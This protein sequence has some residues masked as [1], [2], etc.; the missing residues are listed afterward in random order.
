MNH[1][2]PAIN[3][4]RDYILSKNTYFRNGY[5]NTIVLDG[6]I[7]SDGEGIFPADNLG[8]YFYFRLASNIGFD[9]SNVL[10]I[11]DNH[12]SVGMRYDITMVAFVRDADNDLLINNIVATLGNYQQETLRITKAIRESDFALLEEIKTWSA[13]N[14]K[15]AMERIPEDA[16]I[17]SVAFSIT[18][19]FVFQS[20]N[21]I[22]NPCKVC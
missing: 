2:V 18:V 9:Y 10:D 11:A 4:L 21:C 3:A 6:A 14:R 1:R 12:L 15:A 13:E 22:T 20:P 17:V 19:P 8:N 16:S 5:V 7:V